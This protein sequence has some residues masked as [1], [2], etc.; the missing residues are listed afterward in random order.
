MTGIVTANL[1]QGPALKRAAQNVPVPEAM[2]IVTCDEDA[3]VLDARLAEF[4]E[5]TVALEDVWSAAIDS[6]TS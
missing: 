3:E 6:P 4:D 5:K 2:A 1:E